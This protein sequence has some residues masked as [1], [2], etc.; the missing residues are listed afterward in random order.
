MVVHSPE[1]T[2]LH[3]FFFSPGNCLSLGAAAAATTSRDA[4]GAASNASG[5]TGVPGAAGSRWWCWANTVRAF[6]GGASGADAWKPLE[7][8]R[9]SWRERS[10]RKMHLTR[11]DSDLILKNWRNASCSLSL[12]P[13]TLAAR[14]MRLARARRFTAEGYTRDGREEKKGRSNDQTAGSNGS[15]HRALI[16]FRQC[17]IVERTWWPR[18]LTHLSAFRAR[19]AATV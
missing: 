10:D 18:F 6:E 3:T 15:R 13:E 12:D 19:L 16:N 2:D 11:T 1:L 8:A 17:Q 14:A 9:R 4:G 5:S 7:W